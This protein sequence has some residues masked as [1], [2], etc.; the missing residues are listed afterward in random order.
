MIIM[1]K[2]GVP[3]RTYMINSAIAVVGMLYSTYAIYASGAHGGDRR[4][5]VLALAYLIYGFIA[6][7][8]VPT[9]EAVRSA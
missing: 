3:K 4:H 2:A 8:F 6:H 7:R 9:G 5:V 1:R